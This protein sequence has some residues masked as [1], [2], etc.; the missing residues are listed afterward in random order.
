MYLFLVVFKATC[1]V[2]SRTRSMH[3]AVMNDGQHGAGENDFIQL[4]DQKAVSP[5]GRLMH[6]KKV[7][8]PL[9]FFVSDPWIADRYRGFNKAFVNKIELGGLQHVNKIELGGFQDEALRVV[10]AL[11]PLVKGNLKA[12][13]DDPAIC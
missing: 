4:D 1:L 9:K 10:A 13:K 6:G 8:R 3:A 11:R 12:I 2:P 5:H 7:L